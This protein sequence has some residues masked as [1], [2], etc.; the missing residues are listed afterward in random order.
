MI[1]EAPSIN[2]FL[3]HAAFSDWHVSSEQVNSEGIYVKCSPRR[4]DMHSRW[5]M[6]M[7]TL[8]SSKHALTITADLMLH[9]AFK[10]NSMTPKTIY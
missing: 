3:L 8:Y 7:N 2:M 4:H 1:N 10:E 9:Y 5:R 6:Q